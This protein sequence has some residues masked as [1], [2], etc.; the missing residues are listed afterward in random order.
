[1]G[2][3]APIVHWGFILISLPNLVL[4]PVMLLLFALS[5]VLPF[6]GRHQKP[7][8]AGRGTESGNTRD[9]GDA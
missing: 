5:L 6:P 2:Q 4:I 9:G 1:M 7:T 8:Q 3:P